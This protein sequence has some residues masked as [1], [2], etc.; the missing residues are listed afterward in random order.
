MW[1]AAIQIVERKQDLTGLT[2]KSGF[3]A[4][5]AVEGII[6]QMQSRNK[7]RASSTSGAI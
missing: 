5:Q 3:I 4:T 7:Q 2:P 1:F 6:G